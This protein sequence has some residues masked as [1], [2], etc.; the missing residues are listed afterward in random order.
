MHKQRELDGMIACVKR[1]L[2]VREG[3]EFGYSLA[4]FLDK[5]HQWPQPD[6]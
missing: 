5:V 4:I 6:G 2:K 3:V 1:K